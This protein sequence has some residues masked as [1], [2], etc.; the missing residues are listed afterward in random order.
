MYDFDSLKEYTNY[1]P[2]NNYST[3]CKE[4]KFKYSRKQFNRK[5]MGNS[6]RSLMKSINQ[7]LEGPGAANNIQSSPKQYN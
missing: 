4:K 5:I 7:K 2:H 6:V 1:F 3:V